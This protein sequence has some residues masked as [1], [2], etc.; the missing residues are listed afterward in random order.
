LFQVAC[1]D[2]GGEGQ[3]GISCRAF[4]AKTGEQQVSTMRC[5]ME[6]PIGLLLALQFFVICFN[7]PKYGADAFQKS[8]QQ[9]IRARSLYQHRNSQPLP[10]FSNPSSRSEETREDLQRNSTLVEFSAGEL[11][12]KVH[13]SV[14]EIPA[15]DWDSCLAMN[16]SSDDS[17]CQRSSPF[18]EHA[19]L[20]CLEESGCA[21]ERT[22]WTPSHVSIRIHGKKSS[23]DKISNDQNKNKNDNSPVSALDGFVPVYLKSHSMGEFIFD[24]SWADAAYRSGMEYYPKLLI[25]VPFTPVTGPRIVWHPRVWRKYSK[26]VVAELYHSVGSFLKQYAVSNRW[27]SVHINFCTDQEATLLAGALE[28]PS[29]PDDET[30]NGKDQN[31]KN[32]PLADQFRSI[33]RQLQYTDNNSYLRR[34]SIQYHWKNKN[35]RQNGK[36]F[37][38]FEDYLA[39]F[40]SKRRITTKRERAKVRKDANIRID[41]ISGPDILKVEGLMERMFEIYESTVGKLYWGRQYLTLEFFQLLAKSDFVE[42]L[43]FLLARKDGGS[44]PMKAEDIF[45]GTFNVVKDGVFYGRYWGCLPGYEVQNLHFE[46]CYWSAIEYCITHGLKRIEPG[47]GGSGM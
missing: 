42:N 9:L 8:N 25:G 43:C 3:V 4:T 45:A 21:S 46:T 37:R 36:P 27:S 24:N 12:F 15:E 19:W 7:L 11:E 28:E 23:S 32:N 22:G 17:S 39:C 2:R 29:L 13:S 26:E 1:I 44:F 35:P 47:A 30:S 20:R 6:L 34:T 38:D 33:F 5:Q 31:S 16:C 14:S 40:R 41:A 18:L 10:Q